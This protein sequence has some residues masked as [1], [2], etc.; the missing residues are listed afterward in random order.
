MRRGNGS[1]EP[2]GFEQIRQLQTLLKR[3]GFAIDKVD[4][5][6]GGNTRAA[7]R[8]AQIQLRLP[9]DAYPTTEL[10]RKLGGTVTAG[11]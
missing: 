6:L 7:V 5:K 2:I 4:G 10:M 1:V 11:S 9:A 3:Q 8:A